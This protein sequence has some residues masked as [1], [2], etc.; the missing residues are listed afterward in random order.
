VSFV[1]GAGGSQIGI[2]ADENSVHPRQFID[3]TPGQVAHA[4]LRVVS[5]GVYS[6]ADCGMV[7]AHWLRIYPPNQTAPLYA[8]FSASTCT[9]AEQVLS[10]ETVEAGSS[11][12]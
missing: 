1:T 10:V 5:A 12:P 8:S 7:T 2:P 3:L 4:E 6:P 11:G 9:K